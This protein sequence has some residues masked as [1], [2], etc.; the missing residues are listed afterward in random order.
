MPN[1]EIIVD[2]HK[3]PHD[4]SML[5]TYEDG[6]VRLIQFTGSPTIWEMKTSGGKAPATILT[7]YLDIDPQREAEIILSIDSC[8]VELTEATS[9]I[10]SK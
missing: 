6:T 9:V 2:A 7:S 8:P 10:V 3:A 1:A 5:L 4:R